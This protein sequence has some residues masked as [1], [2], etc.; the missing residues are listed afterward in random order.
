MEP[1][2]AR[3]KTSTTVRFLPLVRFAET[4]APGWVEDRAFAA[5]ARPLR[6]RSRWGGVDRDARAF[7]VDTGDALLRAW[8]WNPEGARGTALLVHGWSGAASQMRAFVAPLVERGF[9]V[10]AVD[11]PAHGTS[12]GRQATIVSLGEALAALGRRVRPR[13]VVAHSLGGTAATLA[14]GRGLSP[15]RMVLLASPVEL[16]PYLRHFARGAGLSDRMV[17]RLLARVERVVGDSVETLDLRRRAPSLSAYAALLVHDRGDA[18]APWAAS[19]Q[20]AAT[21]PGARLITTDGLGHDGVRRDAGVV[22]A[23]AAFAAG[24]AVSH[25]A[26]PLLLSPVPA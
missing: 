21:W 17:E 8:E 23:V 20:L 7:A 1:S 9:H 26:T 10:M 3:P 14:L 24:G 19:E 6:V 16:P 13:V 4:V 22:E 12:P 2:P 11:L 25:P 5:W 15:E 18:V